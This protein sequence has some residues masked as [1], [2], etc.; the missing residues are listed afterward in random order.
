M[1]P[2]LQALFKQ[3]STEPRSRLHQQVDV[4]F[5]GAGGGRRVKM[6]GDPPEQQVEVILSV[7]RSLS[8][9]G[10]ENPP[11]TINPKARQPFFVSKFRL[12]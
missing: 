9:L 10:F 3:A 12:L 8:D 5:L 7:P 2:N 11:Q 1:E 4:V 6:D